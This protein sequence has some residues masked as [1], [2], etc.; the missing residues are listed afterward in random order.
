MRNKKPSAEEIAAETCV[1]IELSELLDSRCHALYPPK[2]RL[3]LYLRVKTENG[4]KPVRLTGAMVA[5]LGLDGQ[6]KGRYLHQLE[7][8]GVVRVRSRAGSRGP[9]PSARGIDDLLPQ[10]LPRAAGPRRLAAQV[11]GKA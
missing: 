10:T 4:R 8:A 1:R 6:G 7:A 2:T 5:D 9:R 11:I 3:Y